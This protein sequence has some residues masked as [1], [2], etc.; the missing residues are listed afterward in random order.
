MNSSGDNKAP[1][2]VVMGGTRGIGQAIVLRALAEGYR[3]ATCARRLPAVGQTLAEAEAEGRYFQQ[4]CDVRSFDAVAAF[5]DE[6]VRR[7]ASVDVAVLNAEINVPR[8]IEKEKIKD[9]GNIISTNVTGCAVS[10]ALLLPAVRNS[11][12]GAMLFIG[13]VVGAQPSPASIYSVTKSAV[14]ALAETFRRHLRKS[15]DRTTVVC[16]LE[17]GWVET[18]FLSSP[19][20]GAL[21]AEAIADAVM[22]VLGKPKGVEIRRLVI[23]PTAQYDY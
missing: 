23:A 20:A 9:W 22:Y 12:R 16:L 11:T 19:R 18:S 8:G 4:V 15:G 6:V 10:A 1:V 7:F 2:M 21:P 14:G 3:V 5:V 13:S 17:P